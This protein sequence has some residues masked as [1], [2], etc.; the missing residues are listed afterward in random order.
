VLTA[1]VQLGLALWLEPRLVW[2]LLL[3]WVYL[4]LMSKEFFV[5]EWLKRRPLLYMFSHMAIM[6]LIDLYATAC[7]WGTNPPHQ[8][9]PGLEWFV[10][11]SYFNGIAIEVGR[12]I[13]APQD[14]E[15][16]VNTYSFLWGPRRAV[17]FWLAFLMLTAL[18][19]AIAAAQIDFFWPV[20]V[21]LALLLTLAGGVAR[22]YLRTPT[23]TTAKR[24]EHLSGIWTLLMYLALGAVPILWRWWVVSGII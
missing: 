14:E 17:L 15:E 20:V 23:T 2:L 9:P 21:L 7:D 4:A 22:R 3:V 18:C 8:A 1:L 10:I 16:G 11:V 13:R 24:I 6:P 19:A 5:A 12:K